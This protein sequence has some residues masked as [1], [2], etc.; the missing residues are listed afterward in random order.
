MK[1]YRDGVDSIYL[2]YWRKQAD[3]KHQRPSDRLTFE[4]QAYSTDWIGGWTAPSVVMDV[5]GKKNICAS[6]ADRSP[7]VK[8]VQKLII[9]YLLLL[10]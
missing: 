4:D 2:G 3:V 5:T 6:A 9:W 10:R 7:S 1:T 8:P